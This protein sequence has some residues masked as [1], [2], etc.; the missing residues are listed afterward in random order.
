MD[1]AETAR[2]H[3]EILG[4]ALEQHEAIRDGD[5]ER[6]LSLLARRA[7]LPAPPSSEQ[8]REWRRRMAELDSANEAALLA[9]RERVDAELDQLRCGQ[10][11]LE[12]YQAH[13][14]VETGFIDRTC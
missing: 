12:G 14:P 7:A 13:V 8:G 11:G 3:D 5:L 6:L 1:S 10:A 4:L 2:R 9:W